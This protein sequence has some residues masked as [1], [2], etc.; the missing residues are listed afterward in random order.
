MK[1][2]PPLNKTDALLLTS[3][4]SFRI[5]ESDGDDR[6]LAMLLKGTLKE[7]VTDQ[8][9]DGKWRK[10]L[11]YDGLT[12]SATID[13]KPIPGAERLTSALKDITL[14]A[15]EIEVAKDG[16]VARNLPDFSKVPQASRAPLS[17][18]SEQVQQSLDSLAF[19]FPA[20]EVEA[21]AT[22]K[23]R[24]SYELGALG[25]VVP[26][27][28]E[29]TYK[30]EGTFVAPNGKTIAVITFKGPLQRVVQPRKKG[31]KA[32]R[33]VKEPKLS[34]QVDGKIEIFAERGVLL[35]ANERIRAELDLDFDGKPAK[36]IGVLSV[37][38]TRLG[39]PPPKK[40]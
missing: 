40:K 9:K 29:V 31:P 27:R 15:S 4:A 23:G 14:L 11:T 32:P 8:T 2:E 21:Q 10:R 6:T 20:S 16:T 33:P 39:A 25:F 13:K 38:A 30:Y 37:Q 28:A 12:T 36:A 17:L 34:G 26:A 35:S 3:D 5:R 7:T 18:A 24:Q 19:P 1:Y 22:W